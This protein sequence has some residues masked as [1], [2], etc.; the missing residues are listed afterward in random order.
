[1]SNGPGCSTNDRWQQGLHALLFRKISVS[2]L[3]FVIF[4]WVTV[5]ALLVEATAEPPEVLRFEDHLDAMGATYSIIAYGSDRARVLGAIDLAFEEV[6]RLDQLLSNYRPTSE[7][8]LVNREAAERSVKVSQELFNLLSACQE[9]SRQSDGAFDITVGPLMKVWGFYK[10]SGRLPHRAEIRGSLTR[11]GYQHIQLDP[12]EQTVRFDRAGVEIDPGGIG[13]GY[14][15][16]RMIAVLKQNDVTSAMVSGGGSSIYGLGAP[17]NE[18]RGWRVSIRDPRDNDRTAQDVYLKNES[19]STSG[20]YE[21]FFKADGRVWSHIMDPRTGMPAPGILQAS[22]L[23]PRTIDSEAWAKPFFI[24]GARILR[25]PSGVP[26][27]ARL[28][29]RGFRVF[30]CEDK[31]DVSCAWLQ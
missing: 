14:A 21:K 26:Y 2:H 29:A 1:M 17:P 8:S 25:D 27:V 3:L 6:K 15:V 22:V 5:G 24:D 31:R 28:K 18:P 11:V 12:K 9:Y 23:A 19:L 4:L 10:G 30:L 13:K 16:D 7:W 20:S